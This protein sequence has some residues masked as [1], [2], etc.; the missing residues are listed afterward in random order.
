MPEAFIIREAGTAD[1]R[2]ISRLM[3]ESF[4]GP[5]STEYKPDFVN[6]MV[7]LWTPAHVARLLANR[8][9]LVACRG[10][11]VIGT[12]SLFQNSLRMFVVRTDQHRA[13]IGGALGEQ[14]IAKAQTRDLA[15]LTVQSTLFAECFYG[16]LGFQRVRTCALY[17]Q[18]YVIMERRLSAN[19]LE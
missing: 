16:S 5:L 9:T 10:A 15:V 1:A 18:S 3:I 7:A 12:A 17:G 8:T 19:P 14:L 11:D 6:Q 4:E 2:A 13:G